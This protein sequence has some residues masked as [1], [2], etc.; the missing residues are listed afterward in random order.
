MKLL[1]LTILLGLLLPG[2]AYAQK[3]SSAVQSKPYN[4][5]TGLEW[6]EMSAGD[7]VENL[8]AAMLLL[9]KNGVKLNYTPDH[10]YDAVYQNLQRDP[11]LY[12]SSVANVLANDVYEKEAQSR[13]AL[14]K[15]KN[16]P[17]SNK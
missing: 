10:Y 5:T 1:L 16:Q 4:E 7:R 9:N 13:E 6:L 11:A 15:L 17:K 2:L 3:D 12:S 14:D 8:L